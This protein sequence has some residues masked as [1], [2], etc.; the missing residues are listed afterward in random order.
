MS[1]IIKDE[2]TGEDIEVYTEA[3]I[4]E[5]EERIKTEAV[6][7]LQA[8]LDKA[9]EDLAKATDDLTKAGDKDQ[10][11]AA[12]RKA[13]DDAET[14]LAE[15]LGNVDKTIEEKLGQFKSDILTSVQQD[16]FN[17]ILKS[18][19]GGDGELAKQIKFQYDRIK[20][21]AGTKEE[22]T[23]KMSDAY[24]LATGPTEPNALNSTVLSSGGVSFQRPGGSSAPLSADEKELGSKFGL[25]DQDLKKFGG[26]K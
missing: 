18:L 6:A 25:N 2:V 17:D 5:R 19:S 9:K 1:Q 16:H 20:D 21:V 24:L 23:K 13:K 4:A 26:T 11:F 8:E 22:M 12:L 10:N 15:A 3:E 14:K 7:P